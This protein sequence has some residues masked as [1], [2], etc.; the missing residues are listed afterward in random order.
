MSEGFKL[1]ETMCN[2]VTH[3][4]I[5]YVTLEPFQVQFND[6]DTLFTCGPLSV[7]I[8]KDNIVAH[9]DNGT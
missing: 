3:S 8:T 1:F 9:W 2:F 7:V 6:D 5:F 4:E